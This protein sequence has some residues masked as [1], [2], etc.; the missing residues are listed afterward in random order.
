MTER[1]VEQEGKRMLEGKRMPK[2]KQ[3][4]EVHSLP[5]LQTRCRSVTRRR[6]GLRLPSCA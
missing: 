6:F 1:L 2:G 5:L 3:M 4:P